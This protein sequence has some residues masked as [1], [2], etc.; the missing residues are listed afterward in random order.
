MK[1]IVDLKIEIVGISF[2]IIH[3]EVGG[4]DIR[5]DHIGFWC[6]SLEIASYIIYLNS[7]FCMKF[8]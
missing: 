3:C 8:G 4:G 6:Q 5:K 2:V 7:L 1:E